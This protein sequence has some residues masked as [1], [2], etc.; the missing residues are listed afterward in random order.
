MI[1]TWFMYTP[2]RMQ[3]FWVNCYNGLFQDHCIGNG[4]FPYPLDCHKFVNCWKGGVKTQLQSCH[5]SNLVFNP[6][7]KQCTWASDPSVKDVC[8]KE[9]GQTPS[10]DEARS[11]VLSDTIDDSC[12]SD[13]SGISAF[14]YDC[15]KFLNCWKGTPIF[16]FCF[17]A[18]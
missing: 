9:S 3:I 13:Y 2:K 11:I 5:P 18:S 17:R 8:N 7:T 12:P 4:Q 14:P 16:L 15:T 6:I 1:R 10:H